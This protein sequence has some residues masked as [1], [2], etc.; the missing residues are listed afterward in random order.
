MQSRHKSRSRTLVELIFLKFVTIK[1]MTKIV[2]KYRN[3]FFTIDFVISLA[4]QVY[5]ARQSGLWP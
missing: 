4:S 3:T 2:Q 5:M 1:Q